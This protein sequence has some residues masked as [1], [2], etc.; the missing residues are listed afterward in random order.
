MKVI[1]AAVFAGLVVAA[2]WLTNRYGMVFDLVTA[3][4]FAAGLVLLVRDWLHEVGG[5]SWVFACIGLGAALSVL[6]STPQFAI[7]SGAAFVVSEVADF[8]VYEPLRRSA[9][10]GSMVLSNTVGAVVDSLLFL[11]LAGFP[12]AHWWTQSVVKV[13]VTLPFVLG[14]VVA[15]AVLRDR[16][17]PE[18]A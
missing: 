8:A 12:L 17:R 5:R 10:V 1:A 7:A 6:M 15:R 9:L 16:L 4:T 2:N 11:A 14:V 18:G 3:G 13:A